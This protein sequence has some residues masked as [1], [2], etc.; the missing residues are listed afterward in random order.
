ML[1]VAATLIVAV[2]VT[3]DH[4]FGR[5]PLCAANFLIVQNHTNGT[6]TVYTSPAPSIVWICGYIVYRNGE[7]KGSFT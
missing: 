6:M 2:T 1:H 4:S 3:C 7:V 5:H